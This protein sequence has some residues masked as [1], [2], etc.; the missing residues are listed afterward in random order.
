MASPDQPTV[1]WWDKVENRWWEMDT[2]FI[3]KTFLRPESSFIDFGA[4]IGPTVLYGATLAKAA[5]ALEPD[6]YAFDEL[7]ANIALNPELQAK[8]WVQWRC[9][10][11]KP[12]IYPMGG[13]GG[14]SMATVGQGSHPKSWK[15]DCL[16]L[17]QFIEEHQIE[18]LDLIKMDTE[19]AEH[20]ILP[21]FKSWLMKQTKKP[22]LWLSIHKWNFGPGGEQAVLD[23]LRLYKRVLEGDSLPVN[24]NTYELCNFCTILATD[25]DTPIYRG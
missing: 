15:V 18:N 8:T 16:T 3:Y 6:P 2:Y 22:T 13:G 17:P 24:P 7:R 11:D 9:I 21:S 10:M 25:L 19:G 20:I 14:D 12:G 1:D 4:W 5:Y 23:V